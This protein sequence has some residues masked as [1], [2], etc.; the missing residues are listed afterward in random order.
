MIMFQ[1]K[2]NFFYCYRWLYELF[3]CIISGNVQII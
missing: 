1:D 2:T 3:C